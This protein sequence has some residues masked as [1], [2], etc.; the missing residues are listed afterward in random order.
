[1]AN[2]C[3]SIVDLYPSDYLAIGLPVASGISWGYPPL[4]AN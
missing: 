4:G 3:A 2:P 1:M